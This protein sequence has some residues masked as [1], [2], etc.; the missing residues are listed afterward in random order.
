M[1]DDARRCALPGCD[2][3]IEPAGGR[4]ERRYCTAAHRA[5][6]RQ[7]RRAGSGSNQCR[8]VPGG[9]Q[10][11][12]GSLPWLREPAGSVPESEGPP[13]GLDA[14][15]PATTRRTC[16]DRPRRRRT[17]A[18][19]GVAGVLAGGYAATASRPE[20]PAPVP[21]QTAPAGESTDVWAQ[22]A[23]VALASVNRQLDT[24]AQAEEEW[25][26]QPASRRSATPAAV[27][28]LE[29]RRSVLQ[30]RRATLQSQ[31]E[32]YR[33]LRA[34]Q[35][36]LAVSEQHLQAVEKA[37][38]GAPSAR[39]RSSEQAAAISAL[40]E[41]RDL[42]IRQRDAQRTELNSLQEGVSTA[43]R[44]PLPDDD[45]TTDEVSRDVLEALREGGHTPEPRDDPTPQR[46]DVVAE[47]QQE[48]GKP[49]QEAGTSGPPDPRGP[50]DESEERR[51]AKQRAAEK[52]DA[53]EKDTLAQLRTRVA[54]AAK[55]A[56]RAEVERKAAATQAADHHAGAP[57]PERAS[58][59][60]SPDIEKTEKPKASER[61]GTERIPDDSETA[62]EAERTRDGSAHATTEHRNDDADGRESP[63]PD[64]ARRTAS[65]EAARSHE[66]DDD[67]IEER[68]TAPAAEKAT[69]AAR[70]GSATG[71]AEEPRRSDTED[72][73]NDQ[74][75][76]TTERSPDK[77]HSTKE[78][79]SDKRHSTE[80]RASNEKHSTKEHS[81]DKKH[82]I[83]ERSSD[84]KGSS[85]TRHRSTERS[86]SDEVHS[87]E[88][89]R[90][91]RKK[92]AS[93]D[94]RSADE[95]RSSTKER[96]SERESD[97]ERSSPKK[98]SSDDKRSGRP[99]R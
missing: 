30:R 27:G 91:S 76:S 33:S 52:D 34:T 96:A 74:K 87:P 59:P 23:T 50:R 68:N 25:K 51:K 88:K 83:K 48:D 26:R 73:S 42:R 9:E 71:R 38:A 5:A 47:R 13:P 32:A 19:L 80:E 67:Q 86:S 92:S 56:R 46:P 61:G 72:R 4:P 55:E 2:V 45:A 36:D 8:P 3:G 7:A 54:Q 35:L 15:S 17:L 77:T 20:P 58:G 39:R 69:P 84:K 85:E 66:A 14:V 40:D 97:E 93:H 65:E 49:R 41:Q 82:S 10:P 75:H 53:P 6:A 99:D 12:S 24:L 1:D 43:A 29:E 37:L 78:R 95:E 81:S 31:L 90:S 60:G 70:H 11:L 16:D 63:D 22:R 94:E 98:H 62:P 21:V 89:K 44:T 18:V 64:A 57:A 79:S 28:A